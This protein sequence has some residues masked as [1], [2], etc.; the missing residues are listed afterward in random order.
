MVEWMSTH[1]SSPSDWAAT[2]FGGC[3]LGHK[4]RDRRLVSYATALAEQPGKLMPELFSKKYDIE[5]TY[6]LLRHREATPD[7]IQ[8]THRRLVKSELKTPG[9]FLLIEDTMFVSY[10]HR[11]KPVEGLGPIGDSEEGRQGFMLHSVL[12]VR[13]PLPAEPDAT[14]RRPPVM[15]L[16][17]LDQQYLVR[18]PRPDAK[19]KQTISR[20]RTERDRE[21]D[22]WLESSRRI[23]PA[24]ADPETRW[25][26]IA[27]REA[28][29][30]EYII[31]CKK[32]NHGFLIRV[33]QDRIILDPANNQRLGLIFDQM[34]GVEPLGGL[35]LDLRTRPEHD[36]HKGYKARRAR[37]LVSCS[38]VRIQSPERPGHAAGTNEPIDCWCVRVWEPDPPEGVERLEWVLYTDQKI[39]TFAEA[40]G[41]VMD[42][43]SRFLIE[44][45]HKGT[46]TGLKIEKLQLDKANRIFAA[47][48]VMSIVALRLLDIRELGKALPDAPATLTGLNPLELEI[49]SLAVNR[50]LTTVASVLLALVRVSHF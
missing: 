11:K 22:R 36:G 1:Q 20:Q 31:E 10:T 42:Y 30:Y 46:K 40:I 18:S 15:I 35:Y 24:P 12:A 29:I 21:S 33:S 43:G 48:A 14:G 16:G 37:L 27:D 45:F 23:G 50:T 25:V 32:R 34:H 19:S 3:W 17:L 7:R 39:E 49:L 8:A 38:A 5:A 13:A 44:E 41:S 2:H 4:S 28:D 6:S 26:R 47:V 9:R